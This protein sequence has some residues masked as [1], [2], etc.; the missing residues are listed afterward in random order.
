M[1][2]QLLPIWWDGVEALQ[3]EGIPKLLCF[4]ESYVYPLHPFKTMM[5]S[6]HMLNF[7]RQ[8]RLHTEGGSHALSLNLGQMHPCSSLGKVIYRV[9]KGP[10]VSKVRG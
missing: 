6:I 7:K 9:L 4:E 1:P 8:K 10:G 3:G 5:F 2:A